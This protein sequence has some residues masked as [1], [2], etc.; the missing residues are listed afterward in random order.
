MAKSLQNLLK[1]ATSATPLTEREQPP[2]AAPPAAERV[3][4]A[5]T[6]DVPLQIVV[7]ESVRRAVEIA[8]A[9]Q[10]TTKRVLVLRALREAG[11]EVPEEELHD[12]RR[13]S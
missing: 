12:R 8:A 10:G 7:P 1:Q 11:I 6:R 13:A 2:V 9:Q 3:K 4:P 5:K